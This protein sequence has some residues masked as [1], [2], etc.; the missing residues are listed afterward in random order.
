VRLCLVEEEA[1][2]EGLLFCVSVCVRCLY[3]SVSVYIS[4]KEEVL[5]KR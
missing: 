5:K 4:F 2:E 3:I 1:A